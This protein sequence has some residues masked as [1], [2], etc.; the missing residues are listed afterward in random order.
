MDYGRDK[1]KQRRKEP[2]LVTR[3]EKLKKRN[4]TM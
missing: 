1:T 3:T 4:K 2:E